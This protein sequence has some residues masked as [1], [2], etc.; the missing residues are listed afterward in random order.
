MLGK[1]LLGISQNSAE[2]DSNSLRQEGNFQGHRR[3][4]VE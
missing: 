4:S 2:S 1:D 3:G